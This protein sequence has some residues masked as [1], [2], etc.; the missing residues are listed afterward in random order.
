MQHELSVW[1]DWVDLVTKILTLAGGLIVAVV[2]AFWAYTKFILERGLLPPSE[3][4]VAGTLIGEQGG[5][6]ILEIVPRIRNVGSDTLVVSNLRV[7]VRYIEK[8]VE[9]PDEPELFQIPADEKFGTLKFPKSLVEHDLKFGKQILVGKKGETLLHKG[10]WILVRKG[11]TV[12][13]DKDDGTPEHEIVLPAKGV[14]VRRAEGRGGRGI[15]ILRYDT[16]V[17]AGVSQEYGFVTA[18]PASATYVLVHCSFRYGVHPGRTETMVLRFARWVGL[19][20]YSL[21]HITEPHTAQ[22]VFQVSGSSK[23]DPV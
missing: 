5:H 3:F 14:E 17:Q 10:K 13:V 8:G 18:V 23:A 12:I 4:T 11:R 21:S 22:R 2:T 7:D 1:L 19:I 20:H 6:K 15:P 9:S 16:F